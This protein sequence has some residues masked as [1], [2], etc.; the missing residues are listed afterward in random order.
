MHNQYL[1]IATLGKAH[2]IKGA[3]SII[4]KTAPESLI[5]SLPLFITIDNEKQ[6][7]SISSFEEHHIKTVCTSSLIPDRTVAESMTGK[8]IYCLEHDFLSQ[9]P[10]QLFG[11]L[12]SGYQVL[13]EDGSMIGTANYVH[14]IHNI[15]MISIT[16]NDQSL[17]LPLKLKALDHTTQVIVLEYTPS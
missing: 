9:Y 14:D 15:P 11:D 13:A 6:S 4:S 8:K 12:C 17:N 10:D 2:G 5:F 1:H 16:S 3:I 7:F